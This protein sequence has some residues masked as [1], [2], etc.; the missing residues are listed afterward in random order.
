MIN[1]YI[2][3]TSILYWSS[4]LHNCRRVYLLC[5]KNNF[6]T[7]LKLKTILR[8]NK[9]LW[10]FVWLWCC[11]R[12]CCIGDAFKIDQRQIMTD[13][14]FI[15]VSLSILLNRFCFKPSK[16]VSDFQSHT[17]TPQKPSKN[18]P[19]K[20]HVNSKECTRHLANSEGVW[21]W[22]HETKSPEQPQREIPHATD[23]FIPTE[24]NAT[25]TCLFGLPPTWNC[26][27]VRTVCNEA[28]FGI[29]WW[30]ALGDCS[31][32]VGSFG[33]I[34]VRDVI[35]LY[36]SFFGP[37]C[38]PPGMAALEE[39]TKKNSQWLRT[40]AISLVGEF[41][42]WCKTTCFFVLFCISTLWWHCVFE[43]ILIS[44]D[45]GCLCTRWGRDRCLPSKEGKSMWGARWKWKG[46][47]NLGM[48]VTSCY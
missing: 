10:M 22:S 20:R 12:P 44:F 43:G 25:R 14:Y 32:V 26:S 1:I 30:K 15:I 17:T 19:Q 37:W 29:R 48:L 35:V 16:L 28:G 46:S 8:K 40:W 38:D 34:L 47:Q 4:L 42:S 23:T 7:V 36:D 31:G 39:A 6:K 41:S 24:N 2:Y 13:S 27:C 9:A 21:N 11:D 18:H 45:W 3:I 33:I 5:T